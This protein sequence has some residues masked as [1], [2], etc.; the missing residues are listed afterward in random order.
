MISANRGES[1]INE[2]AVETTTKKKRKEKEED[3][4]GEKFSVNNGKSEGGS[5]ETNNKYW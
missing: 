3:Y 1:S 2:L 5:V 4:G